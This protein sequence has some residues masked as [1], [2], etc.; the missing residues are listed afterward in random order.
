MK[1][2]GGKKDGKHFDEAVS[3]NDTEE[4]QNSRMSKDTAF[5][6]VPMD[7]DIPTIIPGAEDIPTFTT[8]DEDIPTIMPNVPEFKSAAPSD[9]DDFVSSI[10]S[11]VG[12]EEA[13]KEAPVQPKA[14]AKAAAP[15][16]PKAAAKAA[17]PAQPKAAEPMPAAPAQPVYAEQPAPTKKEL[18]AQAKAEKKAE[19]AAKKAA[20]KHNTA[21][22]APEAAV[23]GGN[24]MQDAARKPKKKRTGL[25]VFAFL[26][27]LLILSVGAGYAIST[28]WVSEGDMDVYDADFDTTAHLD[29]DHTETDDEGVMPGEENNQQVTE[30]DSD[31]KDG[32]FT[33]LVAGRDVESGC[34]D[35]IM[36]GA[37]DTVNHKINIV[38]LPRDTMINK[39]NLKI[40][41]AYQGNL[42]SGGN[43]IDGLLKEIKKICGFDI[44]SWAIVDVDAVARLIDAIGGVYF[45]VP[46]DMVY[47]DGAQS[48]DINI[49]KGYQLLSGED[50]VKVLRFRKGYPNGDLGRIQTQHDFIMA[51]ADQM[52][53]VGN[54]PNLGAAIKVY[55]DCVQTNLSAGNVLFYA[56]EFLKLDKGAIQFVDMPQM[57]GGLVNGQSFVF[58]NPNGWLDVVNEYLNPYK[59]DITQRN[60]S[61]KSSGDGGES[62]FYT[63]G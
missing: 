46:I 55:K 34:T 11:A 28:M 21:Q 2:F 53:D 42:S 23:S 56:K 19:K 38:S 14:A 27:V 12:A 9:E 44:D 54:I 58:I 8:S 63:G 15:T 49:K 17:A 13:V 20:K 40:N 59:E 47:H 3:Q 41:T 50:A 24:T 16:Q 22:P 26:L 48:L 33:F 25:K 32:W 31:R 4:Q 37:L 6:A 60:V 52:L 7:E 10:F 62:F 57:R 45:D 18:K 5:R 35:V 61:I 51:M 43:G 30:V 39:G 1:L 36:V 29:L